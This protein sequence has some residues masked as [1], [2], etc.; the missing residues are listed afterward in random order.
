MSLIARLALGVLAHQTEMSAL[1]VSSLGG[2]MRIMSRSHRGGGSAARG[3]NKWR[4]RLGS[5]KISARRRRRL[6]CLHVGA[7]GGLSGALGIVAAAAYRPHRRPRRGARSAS[8]RGVASAALGVSAAAARRGS[9]AL[10]AGAQLGGVMA[11]AGGSRRRRPR[12]RRL[13]ARRLGSAIAQR[14]VSE[15][16]GGVNMARVAW[17]GGGGLSRKR[18]RRHAW[19]Q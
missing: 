10:V 4:S 1:G 11:A 2:E 7:R 12:R 18:V 15:N 19:R 6:A 3:V 5:A 17:L 13:I 14:G 16:G 8:R 9:S